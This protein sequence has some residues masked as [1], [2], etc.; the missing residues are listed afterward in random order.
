MNC[1][2]AVGDKDRRIYATAI[3]VRDLFNNCAKSC[4]TFVCRHGVNIRDGDGIWASLSTGASE[5][6]SDASTA[7][8]CDVKIVARADSRSGTRDDTLL[9]LSVVV[10]HVPVTEL[11]EVAA[12]VATSGTDS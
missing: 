11:V 12:L 3:I 8:L 9:S 1:D 5:D 2:G 4:T 7:L 10:Q 6:M